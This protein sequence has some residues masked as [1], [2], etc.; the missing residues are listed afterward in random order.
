[1]YGENRLKIT[2]IVWNRETNA[3]I[4]PA[5]KR[6]SETDFQTAFVL[7]YPLFVVRLGFDIVGDGQLRHGSGRL[8]NIA[9]E[10]FQEGNDVF[11][12]FRSQGFTQLRFRHDVDGFIQFPNA[13]VVEV[14]VGA[15]DV[16]QAGNTEEEFVFGFLV[17]S[18][19]PLSCLGSSMCF[20]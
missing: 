11:S 12:V 6:P 15:F 3:P 5:T 1:M 16:S 8:W 10:G 7:C 2:I 20:Q 4:W 14:W 18:A 13:A 19:R 17:T 9:G